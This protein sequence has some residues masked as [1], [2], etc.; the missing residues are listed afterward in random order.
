[1]DE[2]VRLYG[3]TPETAMAYAR[4][5]LT[6]VS[7]TVKVSTVWLGIDHNGYLPG[8]PR[9]IFETMVFGGRLDQQIERYSSEDTAVAGHAE[10]VA[11]ARFAA[12]P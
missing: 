4:V 6:K 2:Y 5:D 11:L 9:A 8:F 1:M 7:D 10:W 12:E 3:D